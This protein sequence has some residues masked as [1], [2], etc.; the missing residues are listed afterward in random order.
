MATSRSGAG[1]GWIDRALLWVPFALLVS[2]TFISTADDPL[3]TLRYATNVLHGHGPV[4]NVGQR[5]EG[6]TSPLHLA[7][8]VVLIAIPYGHALVK[9]KLASL[10]F[11]VLTVHAAGRLVRTAPVPRWATRVGLLLVGSSYLLVYAA[12]NGL[13]TSMAAWLTTLLV[14]RCCD[15]RSPRTPVVTGV[16]AGLC[17]LARPDAALLIT[18]LAL[19]SVAVEKAVPLRARVAWLAPAAAVVAASEVARVWYYG[20][21]LPNTFYAKQVPVATGF[22]KG[23]SYLL[24]SAAPGRGAVSA[25]V[26]ILTLAGLLT[27]LVVGIRV[28][29]GARGPMLYA[30]AAVGAQVAFILRAGGDWMI[31]GRFLAP[32]APELVLMQI[33]G[34]AAIAADL[35]TRDRIPLAST[36]AFAG[37]V[38]VGALAPA[39]IMHGAVWSTA[40]RTTDKALLAAGGYPQTPIWLEGADLLDCAAPGASVAYSEMG[41]APWT[42]ANLKFLDLRGL[43]DPKIA[44][45]TP[46]SDH[47]PDGVVDP[48]WASP[49]SVSG[50]AILAA[51]VQFILVLGTP[52][53][54]RPGGHPPTTVLGGRYTPARS[55]VSGTSELVLYRR[56]DTPCAA[57]LPNAVTQ[58]GTATN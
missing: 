41:W 28:I 7:L 21:W 38:I 26:V 4:F 36:R 47:T 11:G 2:L 54:V 13:E 40:G 9:A 43:T 39:L 5:V 14:T 44:S 49:S 37:L 53:A 1:V 31:G 45:Q 16:I 10:L 23:A 24:T 25:L 35:Q 30:V 3:I 57:S 51:N 8:D 15:G 18:A 50:K 48:N 33:V 55:A 46:A 19:C 42:H 58:L 27:S 29:V 12:G 17:F 6:Y 52:D 20:Q 34:V 32:V 22:V 56:T